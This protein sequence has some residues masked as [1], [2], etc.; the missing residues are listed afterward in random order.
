MSVCN[1]SVTSFKSQYALKGYMDIGHAKACV[2]NE[3]YARSLDGIF[4]L[5]FDDTNPTTHKVY[6]QW[7]GLSSI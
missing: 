5:R 2:L 4:I 3:Y 1:Y 7:N 6:T